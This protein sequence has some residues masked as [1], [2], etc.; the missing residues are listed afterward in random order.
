MPAGEPPSEARDRAALARRDGRL[1]RRRFVMGA[2]SATAL[3]GAGAQIG[4][5]GATTSS[6]PVREVG[7]LPQ[8]RHDGPLSLEEALAARRSH[9]EFTTRP[10]TEV[11]ISQLLWAAQGV[12]AEWGG[13]TAPS[14]GGLYPLELYLLTADAY[15]HY[16][17]DGHRVELLALEDLRTEAAAAALH[18]PAVGDAALTIVITAVYARTVEKYGARGR[19]YVELE[20][21]HVAQNMLLQAVGLGLAAGP[22]G[23]FDDQR[24]AQALRLPG[25][26]APL[27]IVA[28]GHPRTSASP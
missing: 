22:V 15:R 23:A 13:R 16:R 4:G 12:T 6:L 21:G 26:R 5:C 2:S 8:P 25:D 14:A 9:R 18:Q 19:R 3:A 7:S 20:A 11:E 27:Y 24:L 17:P 28:V 10:L 1:T